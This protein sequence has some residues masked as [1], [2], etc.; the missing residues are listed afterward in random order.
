[1]RVALISL[2]TWSKSLIWF[3][4]VLDW[5]YIRISYTNT[6]ISTWIYIKLSLSTTKY[7]IEDFFF[8][9]LE[10]NITLP[11]RKNYISMEN[12]DLWCPGKSYFSICRSSIKCVEEITLNL[13]GD[14]LNW[15]GYDLIWNGYGVVCL[16]KS[17]LIL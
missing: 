3:T 12:V 16:L 6:D 9:C 14:D 5:F 2:S 7:L 8:N 13:N 1:M 4:I 17:T 15:N 10:K 11:L